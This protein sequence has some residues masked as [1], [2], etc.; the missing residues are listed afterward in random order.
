V[1]ASAEPKAVSFDFQSGVKTTVFADGIVEEPF[2]VAAM[3][4]LVAARPVN[5]SGSSGH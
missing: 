2:N 5:A 3:K 4:G 1:P